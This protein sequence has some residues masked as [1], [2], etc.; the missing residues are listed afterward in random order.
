MLWRLLL[1]CTLTGWRTSSFLRTSDILVVINRTGRLWRLG[2]V[3]RC[4]EILLF[5]FRQCN[6]SSCDC[7]NKYSSERKTINWPA[8]ST[9]RLSDYYS[10]F[11]LHVWR[12]AAHDYGTLCFGPV[13]GGSGK[14]MVT[15]AMAKPEDGGAG[16]WSW[17]KP[18]RSGL[19]SCWIHRCF[20]SIRS[21]CL[22]G[23]LF[24]HCDRLHLCPATGCSKRITFN[25]STPS[26]YSA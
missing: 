25:G 4:A 14:G 3:L 9:E 26:H 10:P 7:S 21:C 5:H 6:V 12:V 16:F 24:A 15:S 1:V 11:H 13:F 22:S 17:T 20:F 2:H 19:V 18:C 8:N 23:R